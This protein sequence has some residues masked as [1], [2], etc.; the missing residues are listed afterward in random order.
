[1][2]T[3]FII[4]QDYIFVQDTKEYMKFGVIYEFLNAK[5][6]IDF[7]NLCIYAHICSENKKCSHSLWS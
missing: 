4:Y 6:S 1:M 2:F 5:N 3:Y 7:R